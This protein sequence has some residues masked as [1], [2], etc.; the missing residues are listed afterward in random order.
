MQS[1][2]QQLIDWWREARSVVFF[3]GAGVSTESGVPDFRSSTGIYATHKNSEEILTPMFMNQQPEAFYEFCRKFFM[4]EGVK[5]NAA[6]RALARLEAEHMLDL[7]IT[8]NIDGLHQAA[9]SKR[10]IELHGNANRYLCTRCG[11]EYDLDYVR[12]EPHVPRC[13][14]KNRFADGQCNGMLRPDIVLYEESLSFKN[15]QEAG[16]AIS[17]AELLV[18]GGSSLSVWPAASLIDYLNNGRLVLINQ[19][20]T[21]RDEEADIVIREPIGEVFDTIVDAILEP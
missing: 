19:S 4:T 9:G 20:V 16:H 10:V 1:N 11:H 17:Q 21:N 2:Y 13:S 18:I 6:H 3:G 7:V 5:P 12:K 8:Q 14:A 15:L